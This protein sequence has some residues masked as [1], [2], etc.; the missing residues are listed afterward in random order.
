MSAKPA[1][2]SVRREDATGDRHAPGH[3]SRANEDVRRVHSRH[4]IAID[5][6]LE[7]ESNFYMGLTENLS[8]GGLFIATH[9][10]RPL[11]TAIDV[12]LQLPG[13]GDPVRVRGTVRWIR[14]YSETSDAGP[15]MGLRFDDIT[16][17]NA[18]VIRQFLAERDPLFYDE[19]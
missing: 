17:E 15:G 11:G 3:Q 19:D 6:T 2:A 12:T 14:E 16:D 8:A 1:F 5:V 10:L 13:P 4:D 18:N 7:S 9:T